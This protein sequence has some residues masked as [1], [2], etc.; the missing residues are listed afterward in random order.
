MS[1]KEQ[2]LIACGDI[3]IECE[4]DSATISK[5]FDE[6]RDEI[7]G[8]TVALGH[9]ELPFSDRGSRT[10]VLQKEQKTNKTP[11]CSRR[12]ASDA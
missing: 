2:T 4:N 12:L 3:L 11:E 10:Y 6:V 5:M 7:Q 9:G 1:K 8:A